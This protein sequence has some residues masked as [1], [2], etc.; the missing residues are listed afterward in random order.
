MISEALEFVRREV[1]D[2]LAVS[3]AEAQLESARVLTEEGSEGLTITLINVEEEAALRNTPNMFVVDGLPVQRQPSVFMNLY[4][5]FAFDFPNYGT[6][7][8]NLSETI[9]LFQDRRIYTTADDR[10]DNPFPERAVQLAFDHHNMSFEA[11]NNLWSIMGGTMFPC[12][13]YKVRLVEIRRDV[14]DETLREIDTIE[15]DMSGI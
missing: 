13:I 2:H 7:L 11:L 1:R 4:L 5:L 6:S 9:A 12:V 10:T 15:L 8:F 14:A 3:D